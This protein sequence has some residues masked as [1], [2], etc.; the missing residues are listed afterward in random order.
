MYPQILKK[1]LT[2]NGCTN[3]PKDMGRCDSSTSGDI[4]AP[5]QAAAAC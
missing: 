1:N 2:T 3:K 5:Q 4:R